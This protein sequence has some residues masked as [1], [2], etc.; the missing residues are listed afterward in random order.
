MLLTKLAFNGRT[1]LCGRSEEFDNRAPRSA[2]DDVDESG[3]CSDFP[4]A[5]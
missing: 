2:A 3:A 1:K 4:V 5:T